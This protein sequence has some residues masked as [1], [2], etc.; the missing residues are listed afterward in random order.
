MYIYKIQ[1]IHTPIPI[2]VS[3]ELLM[4]F[5]NIVSEELCLELRPTITVSYK[6]VQRIGLKIHFKEKVSIFFYT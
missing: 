5:S 4:D 2:D 6:P 3:T 1:D